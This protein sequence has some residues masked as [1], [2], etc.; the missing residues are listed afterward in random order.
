MDPGAHHPLVARVDVGYHEGQ[1][2]DPYLVGG[3]IAGSAGALDVL[4]ELQD[5][6]RQGS[7]WAT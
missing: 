4:D 6:S 2:G 1:M 7:G 5:L 3:Q